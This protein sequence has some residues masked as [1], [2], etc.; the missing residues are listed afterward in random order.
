MSQEIDYSHL[1]ARQVANM[2]LSRH[3]AGTY[4]PTEVIIIALSVTGDLE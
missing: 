3:K 2:I 4:Y 1:N